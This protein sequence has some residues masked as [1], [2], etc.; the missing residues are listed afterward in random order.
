[1]FPAAD[2]Q[3]TGQQKLAALQPLV[4]QMLTQYV[5]ANFPDAD[6]VQDASLME[7]AAVDAVNA[8]VKALNAHN[9]KGS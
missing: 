2:G 9:V 3:Q 4:Q 1:M 6:K 8:I 7:S 5:Q